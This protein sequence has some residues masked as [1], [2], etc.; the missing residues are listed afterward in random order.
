MGTNGAWWEDA[1][2][3]LGDSVLSVKQEAKLA[4]KSKDEIIIL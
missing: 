4:V 2:F 3:L 1:E